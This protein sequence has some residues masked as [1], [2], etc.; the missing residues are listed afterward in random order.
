VLVFALWSLAAFV[1]VGTLITF[2]AVKQ[3]RSRAEELATLHASFVVGAVLTPALRGEDLS[4]PLPAATISALDSVVQGQILSDGRDVRVKIWNANGTVVYSD[5]HALIGRSFPD[6]A[7]S[8]GQVMQGHVSSGVSDLA[9]AENLFERRLAAKLFQ[10]YVPLVDAGG[11][12]FAV[13]EVY[14]RYSV[15]DGDVRGLVR[16]LSIVF[17]GG[18]LFLYAALLPIA[19]SASRTLRER[20]AKLGE[21]TAQ[22][23]ALLEREQE[24]V[25]ELRELDRMKDDFVAA[26]S[27]ELRTPLTAIIGALRTLEQPAL[28][29][30][31]LTQEELISAARQRAELLFRLVRNLLRG[32]H[33]EDAAGELNVRDVDLMAILETVIH[34][35]PDGPA[36]V[37]AEIQDCGRIRTDGGRLGD[38]VSNLIDNALKFSPSGSPVS[39]TARL[40]ADVLV[41]EVRDEGIGIEPAHIG[42]VFER[43]HQIDQSAT[44]PFGGLGLGLH[45]VK[46]MATEMGGR[47]SVSSVV[48]RGSVFTVS[49]PLEPAGVRQAS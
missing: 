20:N 16:M 12:A 39:I 29:E 22:L 4:G 34:D 30:D 14:Q 44:R 40:D 3:A 28:A 47:V 41:L 45:L 24:T 15:I 33:L 36:R 25:A 27:H 19:L 32:A 48:G 31:R 5:Q 43:F 38:I 21:Q 18:L 11:H 35:F 7:A 42:S 6:E 17:G 1:M 8:L 2:E 49:I 46:E 37:R 10:T 26:A 13:A 23:G 9:D